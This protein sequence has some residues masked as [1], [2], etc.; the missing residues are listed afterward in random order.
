MLG[1]SHAELLD[2]MSSANMLMTVLWMKYLM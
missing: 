2:G 1:V